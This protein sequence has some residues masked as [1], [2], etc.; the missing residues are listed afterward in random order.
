MTVSV[1]LAAQ[2][3]VGSGLEETRERKRDTC[4]KAEKQKSI[5]IF[6]RTCVLLVPDI[7]F[8]LPRPG[9]FACFFALV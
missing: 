6:T 2:L 1:F 8:L 9:S 4:M 5:S 7:W 3:Q